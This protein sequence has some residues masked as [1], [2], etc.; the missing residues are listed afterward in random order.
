MPIWDM[1]KKLK[2]FPLFITQKNLHKAYYRNCKDTPTIR[3]GIRSFAYKSFSCKVGFSRS[4]IS[5]MLSEI[6]RDPRELP[7]Q[8]NLGKN[9][10]KLHRFQFC[11]KNREFYH[12]NSKVFGVGEIKYAI[13]NFQGAKG[14]TMATKFGQK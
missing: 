6:L 10:Q 7:W 14:V 4:A 8:P 2:Q 13:R 5:N 1:I 12:T 11:A 3:I 9:K